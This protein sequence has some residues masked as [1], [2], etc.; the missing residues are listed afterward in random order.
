LSD[1]QD[2]LTLVGAV[3]TTLVI[4]ATPRFDPEKPAVEG[5]DLTT[6][7]QKWRVA[8]RVVASGDNQGEVV[9]AHAPIIVTCNSDSNTCK[10]EAIDPQVGTITGSSTVSADP[11]QQ[12]EVHLV[13]GST[14]LLVTAGWDHVVGIDPASAAVQWKWPS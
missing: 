3:G 2:D 12:E 4:Q 11:A 13:T 6:G 9:T 14:S 5:V 10:F 7:A 1:K 8:S